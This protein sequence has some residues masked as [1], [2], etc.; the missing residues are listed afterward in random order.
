MIQPITYRGLLLYWLYIKKPRR[1]DYN[2][3]GQRKKEKD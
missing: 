1:K 2:K 3:K